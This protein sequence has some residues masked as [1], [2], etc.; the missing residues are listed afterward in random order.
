MFRSTNVLLDQCSLY[1]TALDK[2]VV[3]ESILSLIYKYI[4]TFTY[5]YAF[6]FF[7]SEFIFYFIYNTVRYDKRIYY[8]NLIRNLLLEFDKGLCGTKYDW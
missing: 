1:E 8:W 6:I 3:D 2:S 4:Y 5:T 7:Y